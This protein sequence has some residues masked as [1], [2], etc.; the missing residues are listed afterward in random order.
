MDFLKLIQEGRVDEFKSK[1]GQR[2]TP[3]RLDLI[4]SK[5]KPKY[6]TW[7]GKVFDNINFEDNFAKKLYQELGFKENNEQKIIRERKY[8]KMTYGR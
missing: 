1:Y 7:V 4:L 5:V 2:F 6:L 3:D 8:I